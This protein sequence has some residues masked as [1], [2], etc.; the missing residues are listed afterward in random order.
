MSKQILF[1]DDEANILQGLRRMLR[2]LRQEWNME[3]AL[4]AD[5]ALERL[6]HTPCDVLVSDMRMPGMD[7]VGLLE[8]VRAKHPGVVR[9]VLSGQ[10]NRESTLA[11]V[12]PAHQYL[13]KPCDAETLQTTIDRALK[14]REHIA[15]STLV[16]IASEVGTL[17]SVPSVYLDLKK[18]LES[19][20]GSVAKAAELI[21]RDPAMIAKILQVVNSAFFGSRREIVSPID[22]VRLLGFDLLQALVLSAGVFGQAADK[23]FAPLAE[24]L[25][26]HSFTTAANAKAIART[27][28]ADAKTVDIVV[29]TALLHDVGKLVL[30]AYDDDYLQLL[31][32]SQQ[33]TQHMWEIEAKTY[34]T[35]HAEVGGYLLSLWGLPDPIAGVVAFH[36]RPQDADDQGLSPLAVVH[37]A[38]GL[39]YTDAGQEAEDNLDSAYLEQ[40]GLTER[41]DEWEHA[42]REAGDG[43]GS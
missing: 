12:G 41:V 15:S 11:A 4:S 36:H 19:Q 33:S 38:N 21:A 27:E 42:C 34:G 2:P 23:S 5:D 9:I 20:D 24:Q 7:G 26:Q 43:G 37:A 31:R 8:E 32:N 18:E 14:L 17:P 1:V 3:F 29:T 35:S 28:N 16:N 40:C 22:A 13:S 25:W 39:A 6:S 30:A 10:A